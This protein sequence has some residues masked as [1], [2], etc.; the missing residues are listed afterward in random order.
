MSY[1]MKE[2]VIW[3][4]CVEYEIKE[5]VIWHVCLEFESVSETF[6]RKMSGLHFYDCAVNYDILER[7]KWS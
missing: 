7:Q 1:E 3:H 5:S 6:N 4:V 2:S